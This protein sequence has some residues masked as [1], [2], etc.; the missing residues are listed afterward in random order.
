M[1]HIPTKPLQYTGRDNLIVIS[2]MW[3]HLPFAHTHP[4]HLFLRRRSQIWTR[5]SMALCTK[6]FSFG[7]FVF[8]IALCKSTLC[9]FCLS[10][11]ALDST[12]VCTA[13]HPVF[14]CLSR[15]SIILYCFSIA[16]DSWARFN[17]K[18]NTVFRN[19]WAMRMRCGLS[20]EILFTAPSIVF[21]VVIT[22]CRG[23]NNRGWSR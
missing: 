12:P 5:P 15:F 22:F 1:G 11:N 9:F 4:P 19:M 21:T 2:I 10:L 20:T 14:H 8:G 13:Y 6:S 3:H 16:Q 7:I 17:V 18:A 23:S